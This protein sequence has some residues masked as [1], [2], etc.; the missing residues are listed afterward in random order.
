MGVTT[1]DN[2]NQILL[3][4]QTL[5][6]GA[7]C[8]NSQKGYEM[9]WKIINSNKMKALIIFIKNRVHSFNTSSF[10][11]FVT[12]LIQI[13]YSYF[14]IVNLNSFFPIFRK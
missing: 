10:T 12:S 11:G 9:F 7:D 13:I 2:N 14:T 4:K 8:K 1:S 3:S 6:V 5:K